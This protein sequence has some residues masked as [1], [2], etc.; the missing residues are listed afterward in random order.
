MF[1]PVIDSLKTRLQFGL[2]SYRL[3]QRINRPVYHPIAKHFTRQLKGSRRGPP[4]IALA[5]LAAAL[6]FFAVARLYGSVGS[7]VIWL[8]PF[9]LTL[10]SLICSPQWIYRI[11]SLI[12]RQGRLDEVS[13][14][15]AGRVFIYLAICQLVLREGDALA[16]TT[17]L[18]KLAGAIVLFAFAMTLFV[19][20]IALENINTSRLSLMLIELSLLSFLI[21]HEHKQSVLLLSLLPMALGRRLNGPIDGAGLVMACYA[22]L[23][24]LSF[25]LALAAPA[26]LQ[27]LARQQPLAADIMALGLAL[28]LALFLL[29]RELF[30]WALW[31]AA[32]HQSN[33]ESG[34]LR[35]STALGGGGSSK[36]EIGIGRVGS[37]GRA[38]RVGAVRRHRPSVAPSAGIIS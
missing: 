34:V 35:H 9:C 8:L 31:R 25:M 28:A 17:L 36:P 6:L 18:R 32:L 15:P 20:L 22:T 7:S 4:V 26:T 5:L 30:I 12:S 10:H 24:V 21:I 1:P 3:W 38:G 19:T 37:L 33:A 11:V 29:V 14:I 13:V 23:Q 16:W 2:L 27:A